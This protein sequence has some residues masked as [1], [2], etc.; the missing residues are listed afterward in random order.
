MQGFL[1]IFAQTRDKLFL[2]SRRDDPVVKER[3]N[4]LQSLDLAYF[5]YREITRNLDEGFKVDPF[6]IRGST[7]INTYPSSITILLVFL[8]NSRKCA[9]PGASTEIKK[10][11]EQPSLASLLLI[12]NFF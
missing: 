12:K 3:E 6:T 7:P 11:S 8:S 4:A 5:K 10:Y 1:T 9:K 2:D